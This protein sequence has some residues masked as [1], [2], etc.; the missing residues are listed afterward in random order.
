MSNKVI[1]TVSEMVQPILDNL[2]LELVDIEFVKEG[3]S[4]F[5]RVFIDS[6]DGVDIEECAKVSEALSEKLDEA[7]PIKQNYFLEVSSPGAERPLK[8]EADFMKALGKN[9]YIK[10]YEPIEGNKEFEGEL[11][12]FD[13][14]NVEVTVMI[15]TRRK[16]INIPYDKVAKAR[17][18]VS[19]N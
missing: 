15:K 6:D 7:D 14:E 5:L 4:W 3:Q 16:T 13:G 17:L 19:F 10:T 1:D 8:K 9:V 11:S 18:A 2:Q 12:A